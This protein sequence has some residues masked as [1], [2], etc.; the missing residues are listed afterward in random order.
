[1]IFLQLRLD[2][3]IAVRPCVAVGPSRARLFVR[4]LPPK[5]TSVRRRTPKPGHAGSMQHPQQPPMDFEENLHLARSSGAVIINKLEGQA[6]QLEQARITPSRGLGSMY[7]PQSLPFL[8]GNPH[9]GAATVEVAL[10]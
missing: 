2:F 6:L 3:R 4:F 5:R 9:S 7:P 8:A 1:M 10:R